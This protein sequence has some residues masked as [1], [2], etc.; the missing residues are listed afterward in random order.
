MAFRSSEPRRN[1]GGAED[2]AGTW[3]EFAE[4]LQAWEG[5][6]ASDAGGGYVMQSQQIPGPET[7]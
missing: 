5:I 6:G 1:N 2:D 4:Q 3:R 7:P